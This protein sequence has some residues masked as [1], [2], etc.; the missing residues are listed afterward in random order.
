MKPL[1][2]LLTTIVIGGCVSSQPA[3]SC[4]GSL[5]CLFDQ[6]ANAIAKVCASDLFLY[7]SGKRKQIN[8]RYGYPYSNSATYH[9]LT[10]M[11]YRVP[12]PQQW[13]RGYA[14][15]QLKVRVNGTLLGYAG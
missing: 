13:C 2:T 6:E 9:A 12:S 1:I 8:E 14:Q 3:E 10:R 5:Q 11:G 4:G 7:P 15:H